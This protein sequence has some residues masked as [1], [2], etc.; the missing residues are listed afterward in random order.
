MFSA[1]K[2]K[3]FFIKCYV[4]MMSQIPNTCMQTRHSQVDIGICVT[5]FSCT[6]PVV[7]I[8][9]QVDLPSYINIYNL[10]LNKSQLMYKFSFFRHLVQR[11]R[12]LVF[13]MSSSRS[14]TE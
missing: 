14:T 13:E 10:F 8:M 5:Q 4:T 3:F 7:H 12:R 11:A 1:Q 6:N 9:T 2:I